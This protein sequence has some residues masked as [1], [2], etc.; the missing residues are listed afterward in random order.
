MISDRAARR[1]DRRQH[2][3]A[4]FDSALT[5]D[6]EFQVLERHDRSH[7]DGL[8][9]VQ[10]FA[11]TDGKHFEDAYLAVW[12][13][14]RSQTEREADAG[15][16]QNRVKAALVLSFL[17]QEEEEVVVGMAKLHLTVLNDV[18]RRDLTRSVVLV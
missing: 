9:E 11:T 8:Q 15:I 3:D 16:G 4:V 1:N 2:V 18:R 17:S 5:F 6:D 13:Q 10:V 14:H 12:E 7:E